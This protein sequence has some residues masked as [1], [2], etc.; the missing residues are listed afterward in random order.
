M[1]KIKLLKKCI[2]SLIIILN[3]NA[4]T[5]IYE[6]NYPNYSIDL[7]K[8]GTNNPSSSDGLYTYNGSSYPLYTIGKT[9]NTPTYKRGIYQ[10]NVS[11]TDV[12]SV[13]IISAIEIS[14]Y[15]EFQT[16][17]TSEVNYFNC[18]ND[19]SVTNLDIQSLW[20]FSDKTLSTP[21]GDGQINTPPGNWTLQLST[22]YAGSNFVNQFKSAIDQNDRFTLGIAWKAESSNSNNHYWKIHSPKIR[23]FYTLPEQLVILDQRLSDDQQAGILKLWEGS[24]WGEDIEPGSDFN[25]PMTSTQTVLG[26]QNILSNEK[27]NNWNN[28][29]TDVKNHHSFTI[30]E[31]TNTLTSY[32]DPTYPGIIVKNAL[33]Q[34]SVNGGDIQFK[35]PWLIDYED[36]YYQHPELLYYYKRNRGMDNDGPDKLEFKSRP[37]PFYPDYTTNYNGDVYQGVFLNQEIA[38]NKPYYSVQAISP[39]TININGRQHNFYFQN[40]TGTNANFENADSLTT[41]VVF[42]NDN[43]VVNA[44][45][46]GTQLSNQTD[47]FDNSSQRKFIKTND[48]VMHHVYES[49]GKVWY[50][51]STN[52]GADWILM[53][54]AKSLS[55]T[56]PSKNPSLS[57]AGTNRIFVIY[58]CQYNNVNYIRLMLIDYTTDAIIDDEFVVSI[59]VSFDE[60]NSSPVIA[61]T[62]NHSQQRWIA[63][64]NE[65]LGD[66]VGLWVVAGK[67]ENGFPN[68]NIVVFPNTITQL[69]PP[70]F[71]QYSPSLQFDH[72]YTSTISK[73][74]ITWQRDN[75]EAWPEMS[76][77]GYAVIQLNITTNNTDYLTFPIID[78]EIAS[79][80]GYQLNTNPSHIIWSDHLARICWIGQR[81]EPT[82]WVSKV[83]FT[84]SD[85]TTHYWVFGNDVT[86][87]S[88]NRSDNF[89]GGTVGYI[90]GW[91]QENG[92]N[93]IV[94]NSLNSSQIKT[95]H[96]TGKYI[97]ISNG[98]YFENMFATSFNTSNST[99]MYF[100]Q[101]NN[102]QSYYYIPSKVSTTS[103]SEGREGIVSKNKLQFYFGMGDIKVDDELI[104]FKDIEESVRFSNVSTLNNYLTSKPFQLSDNSSFYYSVQFGI[105]DTSFAQNTLTANS[106]VTFRV[107][108]VDDNTNQLLGA[109][110]EVT[111]TLANLLQHKN[112][113]YQVNTT[114]IGNRTVRLVLEV[115]DNIEP[116]YA[117]AE[118]YADDNVITKEKYET[119]EYKGKL[120]ITEYALAQ[121]YPNPFNPVTTINYQIPKSGRVVLKVYDILGKEIA[122]LVNE[123]KE[124][125]RYSV[126]FDA[127][128]LS[129]GVYLYELVAND[130]RAVKKLMVIK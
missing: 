21:I 16:Y 56:N 120:G 40:W 91:G 50:E 41:G 24:N 5:I 9:T 23:V 38:P 98:H 129:S 94:N 37:S 61:F 49:M 114:G 109:Y 123:E 68:E 19:L 80:P 102:I 33:E 66:D 36:P 88:I 28:D 65:T 90:I 75:F 127:S 30:T 72:N 10:W 20:N 108:L 121:N 34:S 76:H 113:G 82:G 106:F 105:T 57:N 4:Q 27:Y 59:P 39:Q 67:L 8:A 112:I 70:E 126:N 1:E 107:L 43:A 101:S 104:G 44:N 15:A 6:P 62:V 93:K 31:F 78:H 12:P 111:Y 116:K 97:Q 122:T 85:N 117:L 96:S 92:L 128:K 18:L 124:I 13:A 55:F 32:F 87:A 3:L 73:F 81:E 118:K 26:E 25:F 52:N 35:D 42:T 11:E 95:L 83:L 54:G 53:N 48:G 7:Y 63:G 45:M 60:E 130:Y 51:K 71:R 103:I 22:F 77:I 89:S 125:G 47:A 115:T 17:Q 64:W 29:K 110:D 2:F 46:K 79:S 99:D 74:Q 14:F 58:Q 69:D 86:S 119:I 84:A 100:N